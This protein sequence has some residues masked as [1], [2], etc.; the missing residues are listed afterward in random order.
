MKKAIAGLGVIVVL[1]LLGFAGFRA[2]M[3]GTGAGKISK[4]VPAAEGA[5]VDAHPS[6]LFGR[7]ATVD[8]TT[9]EGRLRW[10]GDQEAFWGNYFNGV[11]SANSWAASVPAERLP[12]ERRPIAIF[13]LEIWQR[14]RPMNLRRLFMSR[15]GDIARMESQGREVSVTLKSGGEVKLNRFE[16][17]DFDDGVRVWDRRRGVVDLD[18][19][20]IRSIE[21]LEPTGSG[22]APNR[23]FGTVRTRAGS[24][25]T[26]FV[27]WDR[28]QCLGADEL[29]GRDRNVRFDAIRWIGR[30]SEN[31]AF[32]KLRDGGEV[33]LSE[34]REVGR[35]NRGIYVDDPRY[36]RVLVSWDAF[37]RFDLSAGGAGPSYS[38]FQRGGPI[39]GSATMRGGRRLAGRLV[40]DLDES[41]VT[42]T[43][44][45]PSRGVDYTVPFGMIASV[46]LAGADDRGGRRARVV[47]HSGEVL[48][49]EGAGDLGKD[50]AGMLVFVDGS[51]RPEY[52]LW[53]EVER[54]D[55]D[56]PAAMYPGLV[57]SR[58]E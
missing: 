13:G 47:L 18:S 9:Y 46:V 8:G 23:L 31:S 57:G 48:D 35:G 55:L 25:F 16:A 41:E 4:T 20:R 1:V 22:G 12:K 44:D 34:T 58:G 42:E 27:Q 17:S 39:R 10:G 50:N 19:L 28:E 24:E 56:R 38:D 54:L 6:F 14:D 2:L 51:E 26:G 49:L 29:H 40:Y 15:F 37:D 43:L 52:V 36:G 21:F 33:V 45:A 5:P 53:G 7:V 30:R 11:K 32:V 3:R